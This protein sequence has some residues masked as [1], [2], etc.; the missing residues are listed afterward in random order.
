MR[1]LGINLYF[2]GLLAC[3]RQKLTTASIAQACLELTLH[4]RLDLNSEQPSCFRP[5]SARIAGVIYHIGLLY[6][7]K[8]TPGDCC[9]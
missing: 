8:E 6:C 5:S 1:S 9:F 2:Y 7:W 3:F 4:H